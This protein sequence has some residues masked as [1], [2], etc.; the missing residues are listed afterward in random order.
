M[1][2]VLDMGN[3]LTKAG[4]F[5]KGTIRQT[6]SVKDKEELQQIV[7]ENTFDAM[8]VS[9]VVDV[10]AWLKSLTDRNAQYMLLDA[11]TPLP[12]TN[13]YLTAQT[14][15]T[16][17]LAAVAGA[18][19]LFPGKCALAIDA[20]SCIT[21]DMLDDQ[22][23]YHGGAI[24]PGVQMRCRAMHTFTAR[25]PLVHIK[26]EQSDD[27]SLLGNHTV[28]ALQSGA[29]YGTLAEITQ[30]IRMY[31]DKFAD[32]QVVICGG[33]AALLGKGLKVAHQI[34]PE[35]LLIGLNAILDYNVK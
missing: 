11:S 35:L 10:P 17:R 7:Q 29:Y 1:N 28:G 15:G 31:E 20:G 19:K 21:Y 3:T 6:F 8:L 25:L 14:L 18:M 5:E 2:L 12:F 27:I 22:Q 26:P 32:L 34:A 33:D 23:C 9:S 4:L 24:S 16:D 13:L 30:M